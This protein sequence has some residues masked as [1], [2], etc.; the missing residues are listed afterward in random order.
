MY[1]NG[2]Y[3]GHGLLN[4]LLVVRNGQKRKN[5]IKLWK[6]RKISAKKERF[7]GRKKKLHRTLISAFGCSITILPFSS[8]WQNCGRKK[9]LM[10]H[11]AFLEIPADQVGTHTSSSPYTH[12]HTHRG[13]SG[14]T[15]E[16]S[17]CSYKKGPEP[18][19][20][21]QTSPGYRA[22]KSYLHKHNHLPP[23]VCTHSAVLGHLVTYNPT[24]TPRGHTKSQSQSHWPP[25]TH[26]PIAPPPDNHNLTHTLTK[27]VPL[28]APAQPQSPNVTQS[29]TSNSH[30]HDADTFTQ[31]HTHHLGTG[32]QLHDHHARRRAVVQ[33]QSRT[34]FGNTHGH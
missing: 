32:S 14:K 3:L 26:R 5:K 11:M 7:Q 12:T 24:Y 9:K 1:Q 29:Q 25:H 22:V 8:Q 10:R 23:P 4:G 31:P 20:S 18:I 27:G 28:V 13:R 30:T 34:H 17:Q 6:T 16:F 21:S 33:S 2:K 19:M 15:E